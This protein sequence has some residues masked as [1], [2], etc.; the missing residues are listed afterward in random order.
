M[1]P[2]FIIDQIRR[3]EDEETTPRPQPT[4]EIPVKERRVTPQDDE[5]Q[6][7]VVVIDLM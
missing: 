1:L 2:P 5:D 7:G 6:R 4:V 3:R